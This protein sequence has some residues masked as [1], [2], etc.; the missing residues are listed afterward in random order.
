LATP[1]RS[2]VPPPG[3]RNAVVGRWTTAAHATVAEP[4]SERVPAAHFWIEEPG[5]DDGEGLRLLPPHPA[6]TSAASV[7]VTTQFLNIPHP[8][9]SVR[10]TSYYI[11]YVV[12]GRYR[13]IRLPH[14][15]RA[16]STHVVVQRS[17]IPYELERTVCSSCAR[18]LNERTLRRTA[19]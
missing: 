6:A 19:A 12:T 8:V 2:I 16:V 14:R 4:A 7:T 3:A 10:C 5:A 15:H 17:G 11:E 1:N 13:L 18:V 9:I